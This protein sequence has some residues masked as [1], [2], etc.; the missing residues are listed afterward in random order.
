MKI[1][2][3]EHFRSVVASGKTAYGLVIT[4]FD[5]SIT[6]M[7]ADCGMD[8]VWIDM[9]HSP[10]TITD[11]QNMLLAVKGT[12]CAAF[13]RVPWCVNYLLKP[14]LDLG[15]AGVI[16]PMVNDPETMQKAIEACHYPIH[17]GERG[18]ATRRQ[19]LFN[20]IP[21]T[22][23]VAA[24]EH[25]PIV[26]A[27][28][29]HRDAVENIDRILEVPGLDSVCI[30]PY[31]L[32]ASYGKAGQFDDPE[33]GAAVDKVI[34]SA[35]AHGVLLGAFCGNA[36]FWKNRHVDWAGLCDDLGFL[37]THLRALLAEHRSAFQK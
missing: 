21:I 13:V 31:D 29:E 35:R 3:L 5:P 22:E 11:V 2:N 20:K 10:M 14:I 25:D 26:I 36:E 7:A 27:Q 37:A 4:S 34:A 6:E 9:E 30:G 15:P 17:G 16:I 8:F 33:I 23:Y 1:N 32:S 19:N 24:S 28:I 18:F 12:D